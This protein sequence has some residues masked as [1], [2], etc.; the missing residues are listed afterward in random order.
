MRGGPPIQGFALTVVKS[1]VVGK[2]VINRMLC[3]SIFSFFFF[4]FCFILAQGGDGE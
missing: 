2:T 1:L 3:T 4:M